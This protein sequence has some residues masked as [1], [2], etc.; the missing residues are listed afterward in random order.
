MSK[1]EDTINLTLRIP[2]SIKLRIEIEAYK[3]KRTVNGY[4][5]NLLQEYFN[6][7]KNSDR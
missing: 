6:Q 7:Q 2:I 1:K 3:E 4:I 5:N